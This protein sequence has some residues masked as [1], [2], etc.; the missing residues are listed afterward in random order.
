MPRPRSCYRRPFGSALIEFTI[1][2]VPLLLAGFGAIETGRWMFARQAV[3]YALFEAARAGTAAGADRAAM[4]AALERGLAPLL[5]MKAEQTA[6]PAVLSAAMRAKLGDWQARHGLPMFR[7]EQIT[8]NAASF[9]DFG[10]HNER[11]GRMLDNSYQRE[12]H[13]TLYSRRYAGGIGP[14]SKQTLFDANTLAL[15]L[16]CLYQPLWPGLAAVLRGL[17]GKEADPYLREAR[18]K[19]LVVIRRDIAL[20]MQSDAR[21]QGY[22]PGDMN[23]GV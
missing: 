12:R 11:A 7:L 9:D 21:E 17:G 15:T 3:A 19:G 18:D 20:P 10:M 22:E 2:A 14:R 13:E 5:G 4:L 23:P 8:P 1:V 6:T 16:T